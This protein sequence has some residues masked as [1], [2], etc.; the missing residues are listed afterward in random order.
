[1]KLGM[2]RVV[3]ISLSIITVVFIMSYTLLAGGV[4]GI[5]DH[6]PIP[7]SDDSNPN[8]VV[9][10]DISNV[11]EGDIVYPS[12]PQKPVVFTDDE[13][14]GTKISKPSTGISTLGELS[15]EYSY[16]TYTYQY[17]ITNKKFVGPTTDDEVITSV[18]RGGSKTVT[19]D[20][21]L[22]ATISFTT[23]AEADVA[24]VVKVG[25]SGSISG[26]VTAKWS[27]TK[28][29]AGPSLD[30][31]YRSIVYYAAMNRN[32]ITAVL[33]KTDHYN[34]YS[35]TNGRRMLKETNAYEESHDKNIS[36]IKLPVRWE[37]SDLIK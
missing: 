31:S 30:S 4:V 34:L 26:T 7:V 33:E 10:Q 8:I 35:Y 29:Y 23:S 28:S 9:G 17:Y 6:T 5:D 37:Y 24:G 18:P 2:K 14:L 32:L 20:K 1:M 36:G 22:S 16:S 13:K 15:Y 11:K 27:E 12:I 19:N 25:I 3:G 21:E